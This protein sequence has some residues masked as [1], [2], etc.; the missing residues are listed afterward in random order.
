MK[1]S[2][3]LE[4]NPEVVTSADVEETTEGKDT[5]KEKRLSGQEGHYAGGHRYMAT[6]I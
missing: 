5:G 3:N 2:L 1:E 6:N 4:N